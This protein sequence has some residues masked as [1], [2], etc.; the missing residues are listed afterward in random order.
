MHPKGYEQE[1]VYRQRWWTFAVLALAIL[2]VV[3]DHTILNVAL[4]TIQKELGATVTQL[5][6]MVDAYILAFATLLLTMGALA[7]RI[8]RATMLRLGML[9]FGVASVG[10]MLSDSAGHLV[11]WSRGVKMDG[12]PATLPGASSGSSGSR[13]R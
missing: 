11:A 3:I 1:K 2:I 4:P 7:D 5:Q 6:W 13:P 12:A 8:G 10:A 9:L